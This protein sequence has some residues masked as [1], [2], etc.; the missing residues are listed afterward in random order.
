MGKGWVTASEG[1]Q[2]V[3]D[4]D[5]AIRKS[6]ALMK[7]SDFKG[8]RLQLE[9]ASKTDQ[10][11]IRADFLLGLFHSPLMAHVN[12]SA[13]KYFERVLQRSPDHVPALNNLAL[14][15]IRQ[16]KYSQGLVH[17]RD[18]ARLAPR[19]LEISHNV[20]L[21]ILAAQNGLIRLTPREQTDFRDLYAQLLVDA[22]E[23]N[24]D[25]QVNRSR[26][27]WRWMLPTLSRDEQKR[28]PIEGNA[29]LRDYASGT[30]FVVAPEY[31]LTNFHVVKD[32]DAV[33]IEVVEDNKEH[34]LS[35]EVVAR[36]NNVD[37]AL[38]RIPD[39]TLPAVSMSMDP[40][41]RGTDILILGYPESQFLGKTLKA[42]RGSITSLPADELGGMLLFDATANPGNSGGPVCDKSANVVGVLTA[43]IRLEQ[44][45]TAGIPAQAAIDFLEK[46]VPD[47]EVSPQ[48]EEL[49][50][51]DV[52]SHVARSTVF[53]RTQRRYYQVAMKTDRTQPG[54]GE[55][56]L[57]DNSCLVCSGTGVLPCNAGGCVRGV[58][59]VRGREAVANERLSGG[60]ISAPVV[61]KKACAECNGTGRRNCPYCSIRLE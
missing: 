1:T 49:D 45:L 39:L 4:A 50:W 20:G 38:L 2:R 48:D 18:A 8:A 30:G 59:S 56:W 44:R 52:D 54:Q 21:V 16:K 43:A 9:K 53:I 51:P 22:T 15:E 26:G 23:Q 32:A 5:E 33:L 58:V 13:E 28:V 61:R 41:R 29:N 34:V 3:K 25:A 55:S 46:H 60:T 24:S 35:A 17:F 10:N 12:E 11:G 19:A 42:T 7:V 37:L 6:E 36:A 14:A 27:G 40:P 47:F 57:E 31:V